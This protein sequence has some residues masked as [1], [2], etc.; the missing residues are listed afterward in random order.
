MST[1]A[2]DTNEIVIRRLWLWMVNEGG[3]SP[4]SEIA[5]GMGLSTKPVSDKLHVMVLRGFAKRV[6]CCG[7]RV[8]SVAFG[9]T[10]DCRVP[11]GFCLRDLRLIFEAEAA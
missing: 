1:L 2:D 4:A 3:Y 11:G 9:V 5:H 10:P 7:P 8:N 6:P